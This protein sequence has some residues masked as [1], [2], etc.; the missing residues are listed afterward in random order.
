MVTA[1]ICSMEDTTPHK[2]ALNGLARVREVARRRSQHLY[3]RIKT[4]LYYLLYIPEI[5]TVP[6]PDPQRRGSNPRNPSDNACTP[7]CIIP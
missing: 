1:C 5:K 7:R 2:T 4:F 3:F 6:N